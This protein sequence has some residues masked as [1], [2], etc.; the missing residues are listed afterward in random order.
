MAGARTC[1]S[2]RRNHLPGNKDEPAGGPSGALNK[3]SNTPTPSLPVFRA[4]TPAPPLVLSSIEELCQQLLKTYAATVKLLE[5]N[6]GS[7]LCKKPFKARFSDLY[8]GNLHMDCYRFCQQCEDHFKTA[9]ASGPN[10][11]PFT[12]LFLYE[13]VVQHRH[14]HKCCSKR[15]QIIW[16]E[17]KDFFRKNLGDDWVFA[18]SL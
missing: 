3:G 10:C 5:Q 4:Q 14:Q 12:A 7:G 11:I 16:T 13:S 15:V 6:H 8:Y 18:N 9:G 17:F 1:R 2:L